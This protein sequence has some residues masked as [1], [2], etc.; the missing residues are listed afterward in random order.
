MD[1]VE[2][3]LEYLPVLLG[4]NLVVYGR[5]HLAVVAVRIG[6]SQFLLLLSE[7]ILDGSEDFILAYETHC[8]GCDEFALGLDFV[9][10]VLAFEFLCLAS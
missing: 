10:E 1:A 3:V 4:G 9:L 8:V 2:V 5:N 7:L 6:V